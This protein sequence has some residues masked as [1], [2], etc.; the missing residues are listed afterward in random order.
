[1]LPANQT[2]TNDLAA[3]LST[4]PDLATL[5]PIIAIASL[6]FLVVRYN[7]NTVQAQESQRLKDEFELPLKLSTYGFIASAVSILTFSAAALGILT[8]IAN[9]VTGALVTLGLILTAVGI[10][11]TVGKVT[12]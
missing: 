11:L 6:S 10:F 2:A 5:A 7:T 8:A 9:V 3:D 12:D 4:Q 1:M